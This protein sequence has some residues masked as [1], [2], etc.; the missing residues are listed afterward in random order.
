MR[1]VLLFLLA[2]LL[3][4]S[5]SAPINTKPTNSSINTA[6]PAY[7]KDVTAY[8]EGKDG[9]VVYFVLVDWNGNEIGS[10]GIVA[11]SF[12]E[13]IAEKDTLLWSTTKEVTQVNF[14]RVTIGQSEQF[15]C[16]LGRLFPQFDG[17]VDTLKVKLV[18]IMP[19]GKSM[20]GNTTLFWG[21]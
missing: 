14:S 20:E 8:R 15:I 19:S 13:N 11:I 17:Y 9:V 12:Y 7:I 16:S 1:W 2:I 3:F 4:T 18:F 21:S 10:D 6:S 5:C